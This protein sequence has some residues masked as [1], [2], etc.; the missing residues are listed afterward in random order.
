MSEYA[1]D[2]EEAAKIKADLAKQMVASGW[3]PD[4]ILEHLSPISDLI[5]TESPSRPSDTG[6]G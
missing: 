1:L 6:D 5:L 3:Q 4:V 2:G